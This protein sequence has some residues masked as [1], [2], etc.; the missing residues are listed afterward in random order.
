MNFTGVTM[1]NYS[2]IFY[3]EIENQFRNSQQ[4]FKP[5]TSRAVTLS[6]LR[7]C[8]SRLYSESV[9]SQEFQPL[10]VDFSFG[11]IKVETLFELH[12]R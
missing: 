7:T 10:G 11:R 9:C 12:N 8:L 4:I 5:S 1:A 3:C 2:V 6:V